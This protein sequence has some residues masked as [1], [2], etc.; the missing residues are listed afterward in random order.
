M[1]M[2]NKNNSL[3]SDIKNV[4]EIILETL[5]AKEMKQSELSDL[6][7]VAKSVLNDVI[8][9][10]RAL[11]A[12]IAV[13]IESALGVSADMLLSIQIRTELEKAYNDE[14]VLAQ[15]RSMSDWAEMNTHVSPI[16]LKKV[17]LLKNNVKDKVKTVMDVFHVESVEEFK[18]LAELESKQ[19]YFKKSDK[20]NVDKSALFTWK[21]YCFDMA[22]KVP[23]KKEFDEQRI[24][25]LNHDL[26]LIFFQNVD[27]YSRIQQTF[28]EYGVRFLY[29]EKVGQV[30][31]DGL[32]FWFDDNPTVVIT[33]RLPNI[34]NLAFSV[35]H[36]L[37]HI[38]LHL[39]KNNNVFINLDG[40]AID[41]IEE[42]ANKYARD[43]FVTQDEWDN[44]MWKVSGYN[45]YTIHIPI[46]K[47]ADKLGVNPQILFGRYMHDTG[48]Y[49]LRRVFPTEVN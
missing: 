10:R 44:F 14:R 38:K 27:T 7:G 1:S 5:E 35:M 36:E 42:E 25:N 21:Y 12:E 11:T 26:K 43:S 9:G 30:P 40:V 8:K 28:M 41:S 49:R 6:T 45:P 18:S 16:V 39:K 33:R 31:V 22:S 19:A 17:G 34:D 29:I 4:G 23:M 3:G 48:L 46:K 13:L 15:L 37:G 20:L 2:T 47:E 24:D 32:S